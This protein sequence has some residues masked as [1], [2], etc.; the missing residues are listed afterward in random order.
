MPEG[1]TES[2]LYF[3]QILKADL[4]NIKFPRGSILLQYMDDLLLCSPSQAFSQEECPLAKA[5][6]LKGT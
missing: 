3:S 6:N 5:F 1:F 2:P 4:D